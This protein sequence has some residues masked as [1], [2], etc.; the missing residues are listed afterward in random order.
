MNTIGRLITDVF[1]GKLDPRI[2]AALAPL[3]NLQIRAIEIAEDA[4]LE[5]RVAQMEKEVAETRDAEQ[6]ARGA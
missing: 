1:A 4:N 5:R 6:S 3:L 2:A